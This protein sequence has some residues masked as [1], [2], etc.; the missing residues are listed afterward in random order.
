VLTTRGRRTVALGLVAGLAGRILGVPELF[1]LAAA[2]V[3][4]ALAA[5]VQVR[6][7]KATV[8][9]G[10]R[11]LPPVV[12]AGE[13]ATL[14]LTIEGSSVAGFLAAP[15]VLVTDRSQGSGLSQP[16][17][18]VIPR[19][20]RGE[21]AS[22][23]FAL[24]TLRRGVIVA[25]GYEATLT[26]PLGL[27]RRRLTSSRAAHCLVLARVEPLTTVLPRGLGW[28]AT[29]STTSA[30]ERL[31]S[32]SSMLR[33]YV[34]GDD[35]R[36][37]HWRTTA[38]VGGLMVREGGD[39]ED[40]ERAGVT[41]L[42]DTGDD[43]TPPELLDRAVEVASSVLSAAAAASSGGACGG[44][45]LATTTGLDSGARQGYAD[46]RDSL[47][48]LARVSASLTGARDRLGAALERLGQPDRDDV[49]VI[50]GAFGG[51]EPDPG[52]LEE[53]ASA[54]SAVVL[55]LVGA[56][57]DGRRGCRPVRSLG[58]VLTVPLPDGR[59]LAEA[60]DTEIGHDEAGE[61]SDLHEVAGAMGAAGATDR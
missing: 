50:V 33:R 47:I 12:D 34:Q 54:Y 11:A 1:G 14:E 32:G 39:R 60:W 58:G 41:V 6:L 10:A 36:L 30:A 16:A 43:T 45:R 61:L 4:V 37:V 55:V 2:A 22:A 26:D 19:L 40:P 31:V 21:R 27:A 8:T 24:G 59:S 29:E 51:S 18:V 25:G 38:R 23:R 9:L 49:L 53:A 52:L 15:V 44:Y 57:A 5:L 3:I 46:L 13:P 7:S 28:L 17:K 48:A 20:A 35:L 56:A 42:L